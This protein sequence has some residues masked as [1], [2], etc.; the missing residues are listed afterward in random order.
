MTVAKKKTTKSRDSRKNHLLK[1]DG[2]EL[3]NENVVIVL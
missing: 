2:E 1:S 3:N